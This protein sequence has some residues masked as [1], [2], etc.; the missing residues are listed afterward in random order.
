MF[1]YLDFLIHSELIELQM[2]ILKPKPVEFK[3]LC[4]TRWSS[5]IR[6]CKAMTV[7]LEVVLLYNYINCHIKTKKWLP[8]RYWGRLSLI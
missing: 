1:L 5:Q 4:L 2:Q 3:Q 8:R 7:T 6:A